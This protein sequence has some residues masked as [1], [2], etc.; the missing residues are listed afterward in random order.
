MAQVYA[1][2]A[3]ASV[4]WNVTKAATIV[5]IPFWAGVFLAVGIT[6]WWQ[7]RDNKNTT[8]KRI[9]QALTGIGA[10]LYIALLIIFFMQFRRMMRGSNI[11]PMTFASSRQAAVGS[12]FGLPGSPS[13]RSYPG[14]GRL[15]R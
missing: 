15:P 12:L 1:A 4:V 11:S 3:G 9:G 10:C 2:Q 5:Y 8:P 6:W 7:N 14:F 13:I